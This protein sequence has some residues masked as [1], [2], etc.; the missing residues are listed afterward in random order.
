VPAPASY[1]LKDMFTELAQFQQVMDQVHA[2][3]RNPEDKARL[4]E[5]L[6]QLKKARAEA[7]EKVPAILVEK[8]QNA[9]M[10]KAEM[11]ELSKQ[12]AQKME[13]LQALRNQAG[14][15]GAEVPSVPPIPEVPIDPKR[16][17]DLRLEVLKAYGGL[18]VR[19]KFS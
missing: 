19:E 14:K 17:Q 13:Q 8:L 5:V 3:L 1:S 18:I 9:Q 12:L 2:R 11:E 10:A 4:G 6:E 16:G 15:P 7:E